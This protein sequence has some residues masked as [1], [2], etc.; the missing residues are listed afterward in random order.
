VSVDHHFEC[1]GLAAELDAL[2]RIGVPMVR[3]HGR[4]LAIQT[5]R[6]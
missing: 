2:T 4:T 6:G 1:R 3:S 5:G